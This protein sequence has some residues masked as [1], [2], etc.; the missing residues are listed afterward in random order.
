MPGSE[1]SRAFSSSMRR[2]SLPSSG[3]SRRRMPRLSRALVHVGIHAI[4][5]VAL[6]VGDHFERQLVVVAQEQRP[7]AGLGNGRCL[8]EDV[9][10]RQAV[11]HAQRHEQPRHERKMKR[12]VAFVALALAEV[13]HRVL[14]PLVGLAQQHAV[15]VF[16]VHVRAQ[17]LEDGVGFRQVFAT[18]ALAFVEIGHGVQP[19]PVHAQV[20]PEIHHLDHFVMHLRVV[21]VEVRLVREEAVPVIGARP[22]RPRSSW[23]PRCP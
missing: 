12:H 15:A 23:R 5:V 9:H 21:P 22:R 16:L 13:G 17:P 18:G 7:L 19:Q 10:D 2:R 20:E 8:F 14:R 11:L 4:H 3:A 1:S 6:L